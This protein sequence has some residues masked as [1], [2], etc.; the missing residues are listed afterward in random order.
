[1]A[2][3]KLDIMRKAA[4]IAIESITDENSLL[5]VAKFSS[6]FELLTNT[7]PMHCTRENKIKIKQ[8]II[9]LTIDSS[10]ENSNAINLSFALKECFDNKGIAPEAANIPRSTIIFS[11]G[12]LAN[13]SSVE[14]LLVAPARTFDCRISAVAIG[15]GAADHF[16][17]AI[18]VKGNGIV[19]VLGVQEHIDERMQHFMHRLTKPTIRDVSFEVLDESI[20][21]VLPS[22]MPNSSFLKGSPFEVF[23]YLGPNDDLEPS[24][25]AVIMHYL[26]DEDSTRKKVNIMLTTRESAYNDDLYKVCV[27]ELILY[28]DDLI[29][30]QADT[31]VL[32]NLGEGWPL[33]LAK[34]NNILTSETSFLAVALD[35]PPSF[36]LD[37]NAKAFDMMEQQG[38][39]AEDTI[40]VKQMIA[41]DYLA[42]KKIVNSGFG[43]TKAVSNR[44][45]NAKN[46]GLKIGDLK[47]K[48]D[49]S[50][51]TT[52]SLGTR[53]DTELMERPSQTTFDDAS[54]KPKS[55]MSKILHEE[56]LD[57]R[58]VFKRALSIFQNKTRRPSF[59]EITEGDDFKTNVM[60]FLSVKTTSNIIGEGSK[61][62]GSD[63]ELQVDDGQGMQSEVETID[64]CK[65]IIDLQQEKGNWKSDQELAKLLGTTM[66]RFSKAVTSTKLDL[67]LVITLAIIQFLTKQFEKDPRAQESIKKAKTYVLSTKKVPSA[68][69]ALALRKVAEIVLPK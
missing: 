44:P 20:I 17:R 54:E 57:E 50:A 37:D 19:E 24:K 9:N 48:T 41:D 4:E 55:I 2:G 30:A 43:L 69:M 64:V 31:A 60:P 56:N 63:D 10:S 33:N 18:A 34:Q 58:G 3:K 49:G 47:R 23:I 40:I 59:D 7:G 28:K 52:Y 61:A 25:T 12:N 36:F 45:L 6:T 26:D 16:L 13:Q 51:S 14:A 46:F 53:G 22:I 8:K 66:D 29:A 27:H 38:M 15:S 35:T 5:L 62:I 39:V 32:K 1:M 67:T 21:Q 68:Q 11:N 65:A 42:V